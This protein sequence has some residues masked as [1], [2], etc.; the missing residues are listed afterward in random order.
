M[1]GEEGKTADDPADRGAV[2]QV[3]GTRG[4]TLQEESE[5]K[6]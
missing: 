5:Y 6:N 1:Q 4:S 2:S 3:L